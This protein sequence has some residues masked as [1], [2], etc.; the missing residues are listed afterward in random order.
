MKVFVLSLSL[1]L[2]TGNSLPAAWLWGEKP[3]CTF[4]GEAAYTSQDFKQWWKYFKDD[5]SSF[6]ERPEPFIDWQ[7]LVRE[8]ERMELYQD[9][10]FQRK[11]DV[12]LK[13]RSLLMLKNEEIDAKLELTPD[14]IRAHYDKEYCPQSQVE[15]L[16]FHDLQIAEQAAAALR[17]GLHDMWYF[18]ERS[19]I[20]GG[21]VYYQEKQLRPQKGNSEWLETVAAMRVGDVSQPLLWKDGYVVFRLLSRIWFDEADFEVHKDNVKRELRK[22]HEAKA[23]ARLV[24][25]LKEKYNVQI[26]Q[27]LLAALD[28]YDMNGD[29]SDAKLITS[30]KSDITVQ[31]FLEQVRKQ[32][33]FINGFGSEKEKQEKLKQR[34]LNNIMAQTLTT[35]AALDRH[36]EEKPPLKEVYEFYTQHRLIKELEK[37]LFEPEAVV[38][39]DEVAAYYRQ[40]EEEFTQPAQVR[41]ARME[42][43][44]EMIDRVWAEIVTGIDFNKVAE[45]YTGKP[46][47]EAAQYSDQLVPVFKEVIDKLSPGEAAPPFLYNGQWLLIKLIDLRK[48]RVE[49]LAVAA[50]KISAKLQQEKFD[51]ARLAFLDLLKTKVAITVNDS[52]WQALYAEMAE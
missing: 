19:N 40:H 28:L 5:G 12:F 13:V 34:V 35:W 48:S 25:D 23:T 46:A 20:H 7:L 22:I 44:G 9:P 49:P 21:E 18:K 1:V 29:K 16:Y 38:S 51:R 42:Y 4:D 52:V 10:A 2:L 30:S 39:Y 31:Q 17:S 32:K 3:L 47:T 6:P 27:E 50:Q 36:Y 33:E 11:V 24:S 43:N 37:R 26:D 14:Q 15:I 41:F 8:A 45:K